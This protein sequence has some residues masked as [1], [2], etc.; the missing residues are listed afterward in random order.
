MTDVDEQIL[1]KE[2]AKQVVE[3]F[4]WRFGEPHLL[5]AYHAALPLVLTPEL[6]NYLRNQFLRG[7]QVPW[8]AEVDLLLS[9]LCS[10]VGYELY[11]MDT[12]IRAYLLEEMEQEQGYGKQR[13]Q[14]V[15]KVLYSY[16][17]YLSRI[18]PGRREK[19]LE[20]Q[21]W[22]A[23]V[24]LG[25][26]SC[27]AAVEEITKR[28]IETSSSIG[29]EQFS[30]SQIRSELARLAQITKEL[31]PQLQEEPK[32]LEC[33]ELVQ[34]FLRAPEQRE[35]GE[36]LKT[37]AISLGGQV[38]G[39]PPIQDFEFEEVTIEF[40]IDASSAIE[41]EPFKFEEV[42]LQVKTVAEVAQEQ[43]F[44]KTGRSFSNVQLSIIRGTL[45]GQT[46]AQVAAS[47]DYDVK[48]LRN[49]GT[50]LWKLLTEAL[51][52]KVTKTNFKTVLEPR[53]TWQRTQQEASGFSEDL[54]NGVKLEMVAIPE[55]SF[56]MGS[57]ETEEGHRSSEE[58]QH[59]VTVQAFLM[60]KYLVTQAQWQAVA[61]LRQ[62][63]RK[64]DRDPSR[65]K[66]KEKPVERVSWYDAVEF[67]SRLSRH[68]GR[69]YRLPSEAEWEYAARAGTTTPF[70]FGETIT[71]EVANYCGIDEKIGGTLY[72]G[73]YGSGP[74][75]EYRQETT[76]VG[77]FGVANAFGLYDIHGNVWEWCADN[78]HSNYEEAPDDG[79][80]W[81]DA[82]E[83]EDSIKVLRG[84]SWNVF[85]GNCRSACRYS[86]YPGVAY[87]YALGFRVVCVSAWTL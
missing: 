28:L 25:D 2:R 51:G 52:K 23:M 10:Q 73:S 36:K 41:L 15:A 4:V 26:A 6:V 46:Y 9:N 71:T 49:L 80:A 78:W 39:F 58:P 87:N 19:E 38:V 37:T 79:S 44:A 66:G 33:A 61:A 47:I 62:V 34:E 74:K 65:F 69:E 75:G 48:D 21:R 82:E 72:K 17:N 32:L 59:Q 16:V 40:E 14:E 13:M 60:G 42:K 11:A 70:H 81:I 76:A 8:V 55:G 86:A 12:H 30:E 24:Y 56:L 68:T 50:K 22:T 84:G 27:K 20:A 67:C 83:E 18:N 45:K 77:N 64:L 3:T 7:Q 54:G 1:Q 31:S 5:L 29:S 63:N 53:L 43:V 35:L 85:P 57:P